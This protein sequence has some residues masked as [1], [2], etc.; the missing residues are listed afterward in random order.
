LQQPP[1]SSR[2]ARLHRRHRRRLGIVGA[3]LCYAVAFA[4]IRLA[5]SKGVGE[6]CWQTCHSSG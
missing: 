4:N 2:R 5:A 3:T 6:V 1:P